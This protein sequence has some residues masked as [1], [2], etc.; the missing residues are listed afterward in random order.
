[1]SRSDQSNK[2]P[3]VVGINAY[4]NPFLAGGVETNVRALL[5]GFWGA[6]KDLVFDLLGHPNYAYLFGPVASSNQR[7]TVWPYD[8]WSQSEKEVDAALQERPDA[9]E[10]EGRFA[11]S[12]TGRKTPEAARNDAFL[13]KRN[14][15]ILHFPS[16]MWFPTR[17]RFIYEPWDLQH[18]HLRSLFTSAEFRERDLRYR[19]GC[20]DAAMVVTATRWVAEDIV[21]AYGVPREKIVVIPRASFIPTE[22]T[23]EE[24]RRELANVG[25]ADDFILYP[26]M[27]FAHK[28][29][30]RLLRALAKVRDEY[31]IR[32][33]LVCSGRIFK[34]MWPQ[35]ETLI[36]D[37]DLGS[38]VKF[39]GSVPDALLVALFK[40]TRFLVFPS[41]F[42]GLGLPVLEAMFHGVPVLA[43]N[44]TC[45]PE[46]IGD[47][48]LLFDGYDVDAIAKS[49]AIASQSAELLPVLRARGYMRLQEYSW[50]GEGGANQLFAAC[51][52]MVAD[53][54]G[55]GEAA[56]L[57]RAHSLR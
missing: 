21:R 1:M 27:C 39:L 56:E 49:L 43:A 44:Q 2:S 50:D 8:H 40:R 35:L 22:L 23:D 6:P 20:E 7:I 33:N 53:P 16:P 30:S 31:G 9:L 55:A 11:L 13:D 51:Y 4:F 48:G 5:K 57:V 54:K 42:E 36:R 38:Q 12:L 34:P 18:R 3:K 29:H 45:L 28:N 52:K 24:A 15:D 37:L 46:V 14:V 10:I 17:R 47:A 25:V 41:L 26:A 19:V 32:L